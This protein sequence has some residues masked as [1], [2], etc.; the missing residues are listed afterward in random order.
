MQHPLFVVKQHPP[1]HPQF[2]SGGPFSAHLRRVDGGPEL[3]MAWIQ[4]KPKNPRLDP[5]QLGRV[6]VNL[7]ESQGC[8]YGFLKM[9][10]TG[11]EGLLDSLLKVI[12]LKDCTPTKFTI[13]TSI[14]I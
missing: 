2:G 4:F 3:L 6:N 7:Y 14:H 10:A 9:T 8:I 12:F 13:Y 1:Q 11:F 5:D